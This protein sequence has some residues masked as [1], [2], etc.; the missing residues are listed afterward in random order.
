MRKGDKVQQKQNKVGKKV[1]ST[2]SEMCEKHKRE[3]ARI[4]YQRKKVNDAL[5]KSGLTDKKMTV[6]YSRLDKINSK[7]DKINSKIFKCGKRY[8]KLKKTRRLIGQRISKLKKEVKDNKDAD[9]REINDKLKEILELNSDYRDLGIAMQMDIVEQS[10]G[11]ISFVSDIVGG[12]SSVSIPIWMIRQEVISFAQTNN[13]EKVFINGVEYNLATQYL[14]LLYALD[15][16]V[17]DTTASQKDSKVTTPML[18]ITEDLD[19][20]TITIG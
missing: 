7:L 9:R 14:D 5:S 8:A 4:Y 18:V 17:V 10:K 19:N 15:D 20:K 1:R 2:N 16:L 13:Y 6:L 3:R 12:T 11:E